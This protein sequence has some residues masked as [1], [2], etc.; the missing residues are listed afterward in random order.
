MKNKFFLLLI[1]STLLIIALSW[2][3]CK[4]QNREETLNKYTGSQSCRSCH[5]EFYELWSNSHHGKAMQPIT[6]SFLKTGIPPMEQDILIE[7]KK[8]RMIIEDTTLICLETDSN[9]LNKYAATWALGGKNVYYFLTPISKGRLQT[10]PLAYDLNDSTWYDNP[11]SAIRHFANGIPDEAVSWKDF[12]YTFNTT[13]YSCHVSQLTTN[14]DMNTLTYNTLWKESGI[15]CETCHGPSGEHI[16]VCEKAGEGIIPEDLKLI[17]TSTFTH[18]QHNS[19][20][21]SCHAK[22]R[23]LTSSYPP[24]ETFFDHFDLITLENPDFYPDGRDLGENYTHA[25]WMQSECVQSGQLDCI[26]CHTSSGRYRFHGTV[27]EGN[28]A[29]LPCHKEN[30][31]NPEAHT[32]HPADTDGSR[33]I[34]CHMPKTKFGRMVRS[35]HSM[36]PPMPSATIEFESPNACNICHDDMSPEWANKF[37][38]EWRD[39]DYQAPVLYNA[40]LIKSAREANWSNLDK[41]LE[42]L[43]SN[44]MDAIFTTSLIRLLAGCESEEKWPSIEKKLD[45]KSPLVRSA[46]ANVMIS[47]PRSEPIKKLINAAKDKYRV[48]R[49]AAASSLSAVPIYNFT[50]EEKQIVENVLEEYKNSLVTRPD[51]WSSHYNLGNF[52]HYQ[53]QLNKAIYSYKTANKLYDQALEPLINSSI[54]YSQL[55]DPANAERSLQQALEI[56][57]ESEAAN[58]NMGLLSAETGKSDMAIEY[59]EKVLEINPESAVS[60][61]NLSILTA[62]E[63]PDKAIEY[64]RQAYK[65]DP[66]NSKYGY[67]YAFFL[68]Q[69]GKT[70]QATGELIMILKK[71]PG[72]ID[73][74]F[75][76]GN[77]YEESGYK[78]KA[79]SLYKESMKLGSV[80]AQIKI[81]LN[82]KLNSLEQSSDPIK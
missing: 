24:G 28:Q 36:R 75:L 39:R 73:A 66:E 31:N 21:A 67:T 57:P 29:C 48:V 34:N 11:K 68:N 82:N 47:N 40:R 78:Q 14:F 41:M 17:I 13:C 3:G 12:L 5:E 30:V 70:K 25:T 64:S 81:Q 60:A 55:N 27:A 8:Y 16:R 44:R 69:K 26:H 37:V 54:V 15:N 62:K 71:D 79:V 7:G 50:S 9:R 33:C 18:D 2:S 72:Y 58:L 51:D 63:N 56:D 52:Y 53:G 6:A 43:D 42:V 19:S 4:N 1:P 49:L 77:I 10:L 80:P 35:D 22:M 46:A 38:K 23:P 32:Y 61:Y 65:S 76:L 59:L 20:C 45:H 74:I